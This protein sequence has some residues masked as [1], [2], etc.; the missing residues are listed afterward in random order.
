[1][2]VEVLVS[3]FHKGKFLEGPIDYSIDL[4]TRGSSWSAAVKNLDGTLDVRSDSL[5]I[6]GVDID[7][8]LR[9]FQKS[10]RINLADVGAVVLVGPLGIVA[11]KGSNFVALAATDLNADQS[12]DITK[13]LTRWEIHQQTLTSKD[14]AFATNQ[15]RLAFNGSVDFARDTIPGFRV[16]V[17][18]KNGCSLMDQQLYGKF[19][20]LKAGKLNVAKTLLGSVI[21]FVDVIVG[22][23]C[24]PIYT[25]QVAHPKVSNSRVL[26]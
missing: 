19:G 2:P 20:D 17:V 21:N 8:I 15:N 25:G 18:D 9:K 23:D 11:T 13:L 14:V 22:K 12:T 5:R 4:A 24:K 1:M 10:Q 26:N 16:A 7:D 3:R 6:Y